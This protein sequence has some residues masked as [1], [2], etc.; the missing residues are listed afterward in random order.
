LIIPA[1]QNRKKGGSNMVINFMIDYAQRIRGYLDSGL[2]LHIEHVDLIVEETRLEVQDKH[3]SLL[4]MGEEFRDEVAK[5][6]ND[7]Q[8]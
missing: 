1:A 4:K 5:Y 6:L 3:D 8:L 7:D 2:E